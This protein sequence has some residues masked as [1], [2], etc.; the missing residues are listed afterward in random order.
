MD[1]KIDIEGVIAEATICG[2]MDDS[3]LLLY[4]IA[5]SLQRVVD[6]LDILIANKKD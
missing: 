3:S 6:Q 5:E 1:R 4:D 2:G